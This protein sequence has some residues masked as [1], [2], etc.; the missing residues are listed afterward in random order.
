MKSRLENEKDN[1]LNML[2]EGKTYK[3][4]SDFYG[5]N[6]IRHFKRAAIKCG[7]IP[8]SKGVYHVPQENKTFICKYC[9]EEF[10]SQYK[11]TGHSTFCS[12]NPNIEHNLIKLSENR[13]K[14]NYKNLLIFKKET[15]YCQFCGREVS[16][17]AC[18]VLHERS[19]KKNPNRVQR[20]VSSKGKSHTAWN[21]GK[22]ALDDE[23]ILNSAIKRRKSIEIGEYIPHKT[24]HTEETKETLRQKM[25]EYI[26]E[27]G[28][29]EFGQHYSKKGCEYIDKLNEE[30]GWHLQH[31][32]NGGEYEVGGYFLDGYDIENNIAFEYDEPYHYENVYNNIL[33]QKDIERENYIKT[34]LGCKFFRYNEKL[35]LLYEN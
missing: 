28:N 32:L 15:L 34:K 6:E 20:F 12:K 24:L 22:T 11:L 3:E 13:G 25:I 10:V 4:I 29:G 9:G 2:S 21:K 26:K 17:K 8:N 5:Y 31:A 18:L 14:I 33:K 1:I 7:I 35:G 16:S 27:N 19:C 23:R 30:K